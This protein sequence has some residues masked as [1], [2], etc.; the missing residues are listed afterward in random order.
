MVAGQFNRGVAKRESTSY[1]RWV[2][3]YDIP[4]FNTSPEQSFLCGSTGAK[5]EWTYKAPRRHISAGA[6]ARE[7]AGE[8]L[9]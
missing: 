9:A 8:L 5:G 7:S 4:R 3:C 6:Q 2:S 1:L